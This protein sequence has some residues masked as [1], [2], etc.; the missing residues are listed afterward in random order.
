MELEPALEALLV[1][2]GYRVTEPDPGCVSWSDGQV[3]EIV[4]RTPE[5]YAF[6]LRERGEEYPAWVNSTSWDLA[7]LLIA[8]KAGKAWRSRHD[9]PRLGTDP[10]AATESGVVVSGVLTGAVVERPG[11]DR[12]SGS[13]L[14]EAHQLART[15]QHPFSG[16][17]TAL[18]A[19]DGAPVFT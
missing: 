8:L 6:S 12:L 15:T 17:L 2:S 9:L 5:G 4:R 3:Q 18:R 13:I 10:V 14:P 11:I 16:V 19:V 7:R 1:D